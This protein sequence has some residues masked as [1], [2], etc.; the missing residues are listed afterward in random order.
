MSSPIPVDSEAPPSAPSPGAPPTGTLAW[1]G[2]FAVFALWVALERVLPIANPWREIL[3]DLVLAAAIVG[4]SRRVLP[5]RAP[6]WGASI[7]LGLAVCALW[8]APDTLL[9]GWR[10]HWL[11]QNSIT[12]H[13]TTSIAP[14]ELT[15]LM[16]ALRTMRAALLV[17]ILEELFWRGW[18][19]R[20]LQDT[21]FERIP[22][23]RYTPFAFWA[24]AALFALEHGPFWEVGLACGIVYNWWMR[25]TRSLGDLVL[26]HAVT[27]LA[28][29]LYV[30]ATARW[31]FWM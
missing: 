20:W 12:G 31:G 22:L 11:F 15:P 26:V 1:V 7:G 27:N 9:P 25:R 23:G 30:I 21:R 19:P 16:L 4:F 14:G 18:L 29:S 3:R 6:H 10:A 17:P 24:T 8:I 5:R 28:L 13:V 2:P